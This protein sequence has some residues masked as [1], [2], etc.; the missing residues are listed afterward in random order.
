M[1]GDQWTNGYWTIA[2]YAKRQYDLG[3][4]FPL[5]ATCLG[6]YNLMLACTNNETDTDSIVTQLEYGDH[7][8]HPLLIKDGNSKILKTFTSSEYNDTTTGEGL[9][10]FSHGYSIT[11]S[12]F[13][14]Y[15]E[16]IEMFNV[17]A[18]SK[19]DDGF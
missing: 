6:Y 18:T 12:T 17:I 2:N 8:V 16:W 1:S 15:P 13:L 19:T 14:R 3:N 4:P 5:W 9:F 11:P 10:Y 7:K